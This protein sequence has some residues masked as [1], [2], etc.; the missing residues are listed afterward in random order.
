MTVT[1]RQSPSGSS[2][3]WGVRGARGREGWEG[4]SRERGEGEGILDWGGEGQGE[5]MECN[6]PH[7]SHFLQCQVAAPMQWTAFDGKITQ[8]NTPYTL[9]A[10]QLRD[11]YSTLAM[12]NLSQEERLDVLLTVKSTVKVFAISYVY[13]LSTIIKFLSH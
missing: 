12:Q 6:D 3:R 13:L 8:M 1:G 4:G 5:G 2:T 9:R 7:R 10:E 11:I